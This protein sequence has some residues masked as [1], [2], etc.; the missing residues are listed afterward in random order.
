MQVELLEEAEVEKTSQDACEHTR[1][2]F[3][4]CKACGVQLA[5][6]GTFSKAKY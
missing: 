1:T 5:V 4:V 2:A 6:E 3:G